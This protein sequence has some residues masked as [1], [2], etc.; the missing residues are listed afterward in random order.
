MPQGGITSA[1]RFGM[2]DMHEV[3]S[4]PRAQ[5]AYT[6]PDPR[7]EKRG[8]ICKALALAL[9]MVASIPVN[10]RPDAIFD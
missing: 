7:C 3:H 9:L 6:K 4:A 8:E 1:L 10:K 2:G 5:Q